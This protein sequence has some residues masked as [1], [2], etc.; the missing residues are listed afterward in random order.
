MLAAI[1]IHGIG[2]K[3]SGK[4]TLAEVLIKEFGFQ[5]IAFGD[6]VKSEV[7]D[8]IRNWDKEDL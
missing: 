4:D 3:G 1:G 2:S 8:A 5:R 6:A 7:S